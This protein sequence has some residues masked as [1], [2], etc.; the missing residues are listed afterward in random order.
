MVQVINLFQICVTDGKTKTENLTWNK[1]YDTK[2]F[3]TDYPYTLEGPFEVDDIVNV[4]CEYGG[5]VKLSCSGSN[6]VRD[7][8]SCTPAPECTTQEV[9]LAPLKGNVTFKQ[10][11]AGETQTSLCPISD[12]GNESHATVICNSKGKW[13]DID[14]SSCGTKPCS[15]TTFS[16]DGV[17]FVI[18]ETELDTD[19][20]GVKCYFE[21]CLDG[22]NCSLL[23]MCTS[24]TCGSKRCSSSLGGLVLI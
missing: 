15:E 9:Q 23:D 17:R 8:D 4:P 14:H 11:F 7:Y 16:R 24:G 12:D 18:K 21:S 1:K 6:I 2:Y 10:V 19:S 5:E 22:D 13:G 3:P 20:S